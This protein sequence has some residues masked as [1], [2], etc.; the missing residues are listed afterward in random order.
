MYSYG[1]EYLT[2]W[3]VVYVGMSS[4]ASILHDQYVW[5]PPTLVDQKY[6]LSCHK[7]ILKCLQNRIISN[8]HLATPLHLSLIVY[9]LSESCASK[10][11]IVQ[12]M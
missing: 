9:F 11:N 6:Y 3:F 7:L 8:D 12:E 5:I 2:S 4:N 10:K 1:I